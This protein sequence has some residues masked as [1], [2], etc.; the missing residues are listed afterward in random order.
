MRF[1][2]PKPHTV[3]PAPL[4]IGQSIPPFMNVI[5][6]P[7]LWLMTSCH[8]AA[9][10]LC[11][12]VFYNESAQLLFWILHTA[13]FCSDISISREDHQEADEQF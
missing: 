3:P 2:A 5:I 1:R 4:S 6:H 9:L 11:L 13:D 8:M 7:H 12:R 10:P